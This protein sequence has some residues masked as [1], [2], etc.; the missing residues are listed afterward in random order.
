LTPQQYVEQC[1]QP[2]AITA[3]LSVLVITPLHVLGMFAMFTKLEK[4]FNPS[5]IAAN[6]RQKKL[7]NRAG[8]RR[9]R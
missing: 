5:R 6:V 2:V 8:R 3:A 9:V 1:K 4:M 7:A